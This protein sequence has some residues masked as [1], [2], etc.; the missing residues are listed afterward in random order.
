MVIGFGAELADALVAGAAEVAALD[1]VVLALLLLLLLL[2]QAASA[3]ASAV[4]AAAA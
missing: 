4:R 2:L 1:G 3:S